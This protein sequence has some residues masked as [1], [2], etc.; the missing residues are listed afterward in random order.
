M[1]L[2][3]DGDQQLRQWTE[4]LPAYTEL[5]DQA[6]EASTAVRLQEDNLA[7]LTA[8][9]RAIADAA[10]GSPPEQLR[11][12]LADAEDIAASRDDLQREI[13]VIEE[14]LDAAIRAVDHERAIAERD[15]ARDRLADVRDATRDRALRRLLLERLRRQHHRLAEP[16]VVAR[17]RQLFAGF[18]HGAHELLIPTDEGEPYR[19]R[20]TRSGRGLALSQLSDGTRAQ[21]LLAARLAHVA[22]AERGVRLPLFLDESLTASDPARFDAVASALLDLVEREGRQ[23]I[24]LT[25]DPADVDA[26]QRLLAARGHDPAPVTDLALLRGQAAA[27]PAARLRDSRPLPP[28]PSTG[29]DAADYAARLNVPRLDP[30]APADAAHVAYVLDD[31]LTLVHQLLC[32][33]AERLGQVVTLASVLAV[34]GLLDDDALASLLARRAALGEFLD[35]FA[36]GR[37]RPA[38]RGI[39]NEQSEVKTSKLTEVD[40]LLADLDG[41]AAALRDALASGRVSRLREDKQDELLDWLSQE[42]YLDTRP[43]LS[44]DE[45]ATRVLQAGQEDIRRRTV[46][47]PTLRRLVDRWWAAAG[48]GDG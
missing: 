29:E 2:P 33:G 32:R 17:A 5:A 7:Q 3:A 21:L 42:G 36:T 25:C 41:D 20:D 8:D 27:A 10:C 6:R 43:R 37:G 34:E 23:L 45:V 16:P 39:L 26:W 12:R 35:A 38:P 19:A 4:A 22:E 47:V 9:L 30:H 24:Y 14:R 48:G 11:D 18:T 13:L 28:A 31:D 15:L 40:T 44:S 46:G 1:G